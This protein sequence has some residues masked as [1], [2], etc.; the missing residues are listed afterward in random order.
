VSAHSFYGAHRRANERDTNQYVAL[1]EK[2]ESTIVYDEEIDLASEFVFLGLRMM[3]GVDL[4]AYE[5]KFGVDLLSKH[6]GDLERLTALGLIEIVE[7]RLRLTGK[8]A[9]FSN[10]VFAAFV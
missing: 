7:N 5:K 4:T 8:G 3:R 6:S 2:N 9:L 1:I 10:E